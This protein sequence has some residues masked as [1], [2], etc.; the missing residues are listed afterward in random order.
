MSSRLQPYKFVDKTTKEMG[1]ETFWMT[2]S[3]AQ[4]G[5]PGYYLVRYSRN[6]AVMI[7]ELKILES[8][9]GICQNTKMQ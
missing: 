1:I 3:E 6:K 8:M 7:K 5:R 2:E 9:E 4:G